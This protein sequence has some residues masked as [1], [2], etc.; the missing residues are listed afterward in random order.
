MK[1]S[2]AGRQGT[3][4]V[5]SAKTAPRGRRGPSGESRDRDGLL[6]ALDRAQGTIEFN[7]DGTIQTAHE[8]FLNLMGYTLD[9]VRGKHHRIFCDPAY[10]ASPAYEAFWAKLRRGEYE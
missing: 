1:G 10:V 2:K 7:L 5:R 8:N 6:A 3:A 9:E 4:R